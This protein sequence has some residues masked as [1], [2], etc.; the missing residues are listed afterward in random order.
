MKR[1]FELSLIEART[2]SEA[3][4]AFEAELRLLGYRYFDAGSMTAAKLSTPK[5][6]MR[7]FYCNY[8][9][10]DIWKYF[11]KGWPVGD[12]ST[13]ALFER[14]TPFDYVA[15]LREAEP[16]MMTRFQLGVLSLYNVRRAWLFPLSTPAN[17]QFVTVYMTGGD[18]DLFARTRD[19]LSVLAGQFLNRLT[20]LHKTG[21]PDGAANVFAGLTAEETACLAALARGLSNPAIAEEIGITANTVRY[22]LKKVFRKLGVSSR[23]EAASVATAAGI[24]SRGGDAEGG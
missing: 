4:D 8:Y 5:E 18:E 12:P 20:E 11:P 9:D 10:G 13:E 7:F 17:L 24:L 22:H 14:T 21:A 1:D 2:F 16:S 19:R 6:A 23:T 15:I 3:G